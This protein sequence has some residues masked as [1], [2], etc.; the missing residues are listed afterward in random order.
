MNDKALTVRKYR[1]GDEY[2]IADVVSKTLRASNSKD[3]P[4]QFIQKNVDEHSAEIIAER[5]NGTQHMYVVCD[6]D[7]IVG[8][9]AI[10]GYWGSKTESYLMTVFVLPEY[11]GFGYGKALLQKL[12]QIA[13]ERGC[14]RLE[15]WC[16]DWNQPSIDFYRSLGAEPMSEW[17][18][19]RLTGETLEAMANG[20]AGKK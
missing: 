18:T 15:W 11:R 12:A 7:V 19:Y 17:T 16:L 20:T 8:C 3:Y 13:L 5:A 9:G 2:G 4:P 14:G 1:S 6:G 10:D